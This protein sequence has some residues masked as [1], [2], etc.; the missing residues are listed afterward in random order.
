MHNHFKQAI[1]FAFSSSHT[2]KEPVK[3]RN[4]DHLKLEQ[5]AFIGGVAA[6]RK[7]VIYVILSKNIL[8]I[9]DR[10]R[11]VAVMRNT[12]IYCS[13]LYLIDVIRLM[14]SNTHA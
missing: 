14:S 4:S 8:R 5:V 10:H 3:P 13:I 9:S 2:A 7:F 1:V 11:E 6:F 12:T